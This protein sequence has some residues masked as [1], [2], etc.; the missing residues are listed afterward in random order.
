MSLPLQRLGRMSPQVH[1]ARLFFHD[2]KEKRLFALESRHQT[3]KITSPEI[4]IFAP[5]PC[6]HSSQFLV[7]FRTSFPKIITFLVPHSCTAYTLFVIAVRTWP[8][9]GAANCSS[10]SPNISHGSTRRYVLRP[11]CTLY[12][13]LQCTQQNKQVLLG[14]PHSDILQCSRVQHQRNACQ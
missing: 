10:T 11:S 1:Q 13:T 5:T 3:F 7:K 9:S 4:T 14:F 12:R 2:C 6:V 8:N